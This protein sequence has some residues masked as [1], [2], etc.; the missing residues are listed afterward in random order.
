MEERL[1]SWGNKNKTIILH[2]SFYTHLLVCMLR[3]NLQM[4]IQSK[5]GSFCYLSLQGYVFIAVCVT[6]SL[7]RQKKNT[8]IL[9]HLVEEWGAKE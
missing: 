2:W 5:G 4:C 7:S 8:P 3:F 9:I 1:Q 6:D